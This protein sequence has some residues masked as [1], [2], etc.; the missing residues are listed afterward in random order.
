MPTH[1]IVNFGRNVRVAPRH[2]Y[3]PATEAEVLAILDRHSSGK[4]RVIGALHAW[5]PAIEC[6][7]AIVDLRRFNHVEIERTADGA[8]WATIGGGCRIKHLLRKL[9]ALADV[10]LPSVGLITE[11][12]IAGAIATATHGSGKSSLSH[13]VDEIRVAAYDPATGKARFYTWDTGAELR[14]ARCAVGCMGIVLSVRIR[15]VPRYEVAETVVPCATL[16]EVLAEED[17]FLLQQFY[18][19]PHRW[20]YFVQRRV[21]A[22]FRDRRSW[23]AKLYR[24]YWFLGIDLGLH[25]II[26]MLVSVLQDRAAARW[27][28]RR[29]LPLLIVRNTTVQDHAERMMTM[30]HEL[31]RHL[32]I[33]IFVPQR[34]V[35][36]AATF[37]QAILQVFDGALA[38]PPVEIASALAQIGLADELRHLR[39]T[40]THHYP[41]TWRR[42]LPDDTLISMT[43]GGEP[44]YAI[45]FITYQEPRDRFLA[46][47]S[48]L[49][50]SMMARFDGRLHWGKHFPASGA[51]VAHA[52]ADLAEFRALCQQVDPRGVFRNAF[53]ERVL[54]R[55]GR[56]RPEHR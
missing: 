25:L 6:A 9:H 32:E 29:I 19:I 56:P 18:L 37:V 13:Y 12:T 5:S 43:S 14:A 52:Y 46:L 7:D 15:C 17:R 41:I 44:W 47:A 20:T 45:S 1:A 26:K 27:F 24:A 21:A 48:F 36:P 8:V 54:F 2:L 40:F 10:T 16:D 4:V 42:V 39:G 30:R 3:T 35:R 33:E 23:S 38:E 50:R 28:H 31:F 34:N 22:P 11:Q 51:D 55:D 49:A 53:I